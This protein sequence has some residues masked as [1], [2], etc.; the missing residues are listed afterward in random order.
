[1]NEN[2]VK[3]NSTWRICEKTSLG[4]DFE[5]LLNVQETKNAEK[6]DVDAISFL[7][8][9]DMEHYLYLLSPEKDEERCLLTLSTTKGTFESVNLVTDSRN[10]EIFIA[11]MDQIASYWKTFK[12]NV[13]EEL[14]EL[15]NETFLHEI[16]FDCSVRHVEL[17]LGKS[18]DKALY[19]FGLKVTIKPGSDSS[20]KMLPFAPSSSIDFKN[21][22]SMLS[23]SNVPISAGA[24]KALTFL[25][26]S[27]KS[28]APPAMPPNMEVLM[29]ML[30]QAS[31]QSS[32]NPKVPEL[33][34]PS[35]SKTEKSTKDMPPFG[36]NP[37]EMVKSYL[38]VRLKEMQNEIMKD[39]DAKL[40]GFEERQNQKFDQIIKMLKKK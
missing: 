40:K 5:S 22:E 26:Q 24:E 9:V 12:G 4:T 10:V 7:D 33:E 34:A 25:K 36:S 21:V 8:V 2:P 6:D 14:S 38:D 31:I 29:N 1:M 37:L 17:K 15:G 35:T 39:F 13:I 30:N 20:H 11:D 23:N 16:C 27:G 28:F 19:L 18:S 32:Q 3:I